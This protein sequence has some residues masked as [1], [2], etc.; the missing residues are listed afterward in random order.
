MLILVLGWYFIHPCVVDAQQRTHTVKK[1]DTLWDISEMYYGD[2]YLWPKL[3][4]INPFVTN[5]HFLHQGDL[6]RLLESKPVKRIEREVKTA[7]EA[8]PEP[9]PAMAGIDVSGLTN[10]NALGYLSPREVKPWG[11]I[12][13]SDS[14]KTLLSKGDTVFVEFI[15]YETIKPG[16]EFTIFQPTPLLRHPL[17]GKN[18][19]Y[20]LYFHGRLVI[21]ENFEKGVFRARIVEAFGQVKVGAKLLPSEPL[22]ACLQPL[23]VK[24]E[25]FASIVAAKDQKQ[26]IGRH[27]V[28]Y[29][30]RGFKH[31]VRR[32]N[33]FEIIKMRSVPDLTAEPT[34]LDDYIRVK[35][36]TIPQKLLGRILI[37][38]SRPETATALVLSAV[39]NV[40]T[41]TFVRGL[42]WEKTPEFLSSI[43]SC[44]I[45]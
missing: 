23:S 1:G 13:S 27:S 42:S 36:V 30:D 6:I 12:L 2:P 34:T 8:V 28:V 26:I 19:G 24:G 25:V 33:I 18:L 10:I 22:L 45:E 43:P 39:E 17:V 29:I 41:G 38:Q 3:W 15:F 4:R 21:E 40:Q 31:G 35:E 16:D 14:E 9:V 7:V 20:S 11:S 5:P 32:G 44:P 37:L